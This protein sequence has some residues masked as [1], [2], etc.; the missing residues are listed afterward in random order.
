VDPRLERKAGEPLIEKKWTSGFSGTDL[1][2]RL[3]EA[4]ADCLVITGLTT[5]GCVRATALDA[6]QHEFPVF[7]PRSAVGDRN[8]EAHEANLHDLHAK[9]AD[10]L[11][12]DDLM[13]TLEG[14]A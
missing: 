4:G 10:V 9:Y 5:S 6:L 3:T 13:R 12:L 2:D 7:I 8:Q 11:A 14:V 1:A